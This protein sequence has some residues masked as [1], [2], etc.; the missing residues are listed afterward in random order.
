M[1]RP[2]VG[3][4]LVLA[5]TLPAFSQNEIT[6]Q[7]LHSAF[8]GIN[9]G[10]TD[11]SIFCPDPDAF[12]IGHQW[13]A[14]SFR[15]ANQA[16]G[17]NFTND[18]WSYLGGSGDDSARKMQSLSRLDPGV[19]NYLGWALGAWQWRHD[20]TLT[21]LFITPWLG[22]RFDCSENGSASDTWA[23]RDSASWPYGFEARHHGYVPTSS[24][25]EN[26]RRYVLLKDS[27][28]GSGT[29]RIVLDS[30]QPRTQIYN[31]HGQKPHNFALADSMSGWRMLLV[32]N[33]RLLD[34]SDGADA[35]A[36][37]IKMQVRGHR[38]EPDPLDPDLNK[39]GSPVYFNFDSIPG[40]SLAYVQELPHSRGKVMRMMGVSDKPTE[41]ILRR[42]QLPEGS[43]RD[44]TFTA[45]FRTDAV[46][47]LVDD[48]LE[49]QDAHLKTKQYLSHGIPGAS[50]QFIDT[51][52]PVI[53]WYDTVSVAIRSV[54][55]MPPGVFNATCGWYDSLFAVAFAGERELI[56]QAQDYWRDSVG[57]SQGLYV[58]HYYPVD[59]YMHYEDMGM[60]YRT[61]LLNGLVSSETGYEGRV[62]GQNRVYTEGDG[63]K[64]AHMMGAPFLW[65]SIGQVALRTTR[66][67]M[68]PYV[69]WEWEHHR[70]TSSTPYPSLG[71]RGGF[72]FEVPDSLK[73]KYYEH[74]ETIGET[75]YFDSTVPYDTYQKFSIPMQPQFADSVVYGWVLHPDAGG[76]VQT[77]YEHSLY[78]RIYCQQS[79]YFGKPKQRHLI[80]LFYLK[81]MHLGKNNI[82]APY[83]NFFKIR[84][85]SGEEVRLELGSGLAFGAKGLVYDKFYDHPNVSYPNVSELDTPDTVACVPG[86]ITNRTTTDWDTEAGVTP[87]NILRRDELGSDFIE[88]N[89][90]WKITQCRNLADY[91]ADMEVGNAYPQ[92]D[93]MRVYYGQKS[94]RTEIKKWHDL[95]RN[96][97]TRDQIWKMWPVAWVGTGYKRLKGGNIAEMKR[98]I[99]T[100][101]AAVRMWKWTKEYTNDAMWKLVEEPD[102]ERLYDFI[103]L[104]TRDSVGQVTDSCIVAVINRRTDPHVIDGAYAD[105]IRVYT[106]VEFDSLAAGDAAWTYRQLGARRISIPFNYTH[107]QNTSIL[108]EI[109]EITLD[110]TRR[111]DTVIAGT[112]DLAVDFKPGE[113]RF[114]SIKRRPA[115]IAVGSGFLALNTQ[116]K[117]VAYPVPDGAGGY[118]DSI[119]YHM[120]YHAKD[121]AID[122]AGVWTVF[123]KRSL[124]YHRD[125]MPSVAGLQW[126]TTSYRLSRQTHLNRPAT[127]ATDS[128]R[129]FPGVSPLLYGPT[130][131]T[132]ETLDLSC[133]FPSIVVRED[134]AGYPRIHVVYACQDQ[135]A[136]EYNNY[137]HIVENAFADQEYPDIGQLETGGRSL[138]VCYKNLNHD[139]DSL[140][141]LAQWGTPV[142]NAS[143]TNRLFYAWSASGRGIGVGTKTASAP[144]FPANGSIMELPRPAFGTIE[145]NTAAQYPS[146]NVYSNIG[147]NTQNAS[148]VWQ[149]GN[150]IRYTRVRAD[151]NPLLIANYLP[152][153]KGMNYAGG[154]PALPYNNTAGIAI[155]SDTTVSAE[156]ELPVVTR[157]LTTDPMTVFIRDTTNGYDD[158]YHYGHESI[159]WQQY[160]PASP[161]QRSQ[162]RHRQFFDFPEITS[163]GTL[164]Y[165]YTGTT[166]SGSHSLFSPVQTQGIVRRDSLTWEGWENDTTLHT[167]GQLLKIESGNLSDS[168]IV[169]NYNVLAKSL[170]QHVRNAR[171]A[172]QATWWQGTEQF[173]AIQTQQIMLRPFPPLPAPPSGPTLHFN[174]VYEGGTWPHL[175]MRQ[176]EDWPGGLQTVRRVVQRTNASVPGVLASAEGF[177]KLTDHENESNLDYS[178]QPVAVARGFSTATGDVA[179]EVFLESGRALAFTSD[180]TP[181]GWRAAFGPT[182]LISEPF[183]VGTMRV[184]ETAVTGQKRNG[185]QLSI[186]EV[187]SNCTPEPSD[188]GLPE[189]A[190]TQDTS[191]HDT[192]ACSKQTVYLAE[193]QGRTYR[194]RLAY[195]AEEPCVYYEMRNISPDTVAFEKAASAPATI[196]HLQARTTTEVRHTATIQCFPNPATDRI[197]VLLPKADQPRTLVVLNMMGAVQTTEYLGNATDYMINV[198]AW[199]QGSYVI[200]VHGNETVLPHTANVN[201]MR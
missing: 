198:S 69:N 158:S 118:R 36:R 49:L 151:G 182:Q 139:A 121:T 104:D 38:F 150:H 102:A 103:L 122:R 123:Y 133:G 85:M 193:G 20:S 196:V 9:T 56:E 7:P 10:L 110:S 80:N 128:T 35:G 179:L 116:N 187:C 132:D 144:Y 111:I 174:Y 54:S 191:S 149:E 59:E 165:W 39:R 180:T 5:C 197:L 87:D 119:R 117:L 75:N 186:E 91:A 94:M 172:G 168:A 200:H 95:I 131:A 159:T 153:L 109:S 6:P 47:K 12:L 14:S 161:H 173:T 115:S 11:T 15:R 51:L 97:S 13:A 177:Y 90:P 190:Q 83:V 105:S 167:Y 93:S 181:Q 194:L 126:D 155:M 71:Q 137:M 112:T 178:P 72:E 166:F 135:W 22:Y 160:L 98:W 76:S 146:V 92:P 185:V 34:S 42:A 130:I 120:V 108:L 29:E 134:S 3:C 152:Q 2:I 86:L 101:R 189:A 114:F 136:E 154:P 25:D 44:I 74:Y 192:Q 19:T 37:V 175:A 27:S 89:H 61:K 124:A 46:Y 201:I 30:C 33:L 96:S 184:I 16:L 66:S 78:T 107:Y 143:A 23:P 64:R 68:V 125:Q 77:A 147:L 45:E 129:L 183:T 100:S 81:E 195:T 50:A 52:T 141:D 67:P 28:A 48:S 171:L 21:K 99:D 163:N 162:I 142:I 18:H 113:T 60:Y 1:T 138:V 43:G 62:A 169:L 26:Y 73:K 65:T 53:S 88:P 31:A 84:P 40:P 24:S 170:Y 70:K 199:P 8:P 55:I 188:V 4:L 58:T 57:S 140:T 127:T 156:N 106:T 82:G 41:V 176:R 164:N 32:V 63:I 79:L 148:V 157:S 145:A 17:C